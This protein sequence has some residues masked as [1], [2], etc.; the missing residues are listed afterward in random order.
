V[1]SA[2]LVIFVNN[3]GTHVKNFPVGNYLGELTNEISREQKHIVEYDSGGT[4]NYAFRTVD[5][6]E[7]CK[8]LYSELFSISIRISPQ[9]RFHYS[10][11]IDNF[12]FL[13]LPFLIQF[14][15][16]RMP[17]YLRGISEN[18][19]LCSSVYYQV[20]QCI[21]VY[22]LTAILNIIISFIVKKI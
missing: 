2:D 3:N 7:V 14:P 18:Y 17:R 15:L 11:R 6:S 16:S 20:L 12:I 22:Q 1:G 21:E 8:V 5:G 10:L 9:I 4:K 13:I 19:G